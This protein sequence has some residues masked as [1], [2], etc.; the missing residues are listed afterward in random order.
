MNYI[1]PDYKNSIYN[2]HYAILDY[3]GIKNKEKGKIE[4]ENKRNKLLFI[5]VDSFGVNLLKKLNLKLEYH[6]MTSVLPSSTV[7]SLP[8]FFFGLRPSEHM[9]FIRTKTPKL[10]G[11]LLWFPYYYVYP[12]RC[13]PIVD[14]TFVYNFDTVF[15]KLKKKEIKSLTIIPSNL[16]NTPLT[17]VLYKDSDLKFYLNWFDA[18]ELILKYKNYDFII[19]YLMELDDLSHQ[20]GV[21]S[22]SVLLALKYVFKLV[23]DIKEKNIFD[24]IISSDHGQTNVNKMRLLEELQ[25][26]PNVERIY[27]DRR[28][29]MIDGE[30]ESIEEIFPEKYYFVFSRKEAFKLLG[31]RG[32]K[33]I[34]PNYLIVPKKGEEMRIRLGYDDKPESEFK[35]AHG[36]LTEDEQKIPLIIF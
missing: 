34:M 6:E 1:F 27:G 35:S 33:R 15:T 21:N 4:L 32:N 22:Q 5:F 17:K 14:I 10:A 7:T 16:E 24:I 8:S 36:G 26:N 23:E 2:L 3:F 20:Y 13:A 11:T 29:I 30:L 18:V 12:A 28:A 31:N 9:I 19:W 25:N